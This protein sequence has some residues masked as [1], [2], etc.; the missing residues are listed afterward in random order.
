MLDGESQLS[1]SYTLS[2]LQSSVVNFLCCYY[3]VMVIGSKLLCLLKCMKKYV[4][5]KCCSPAPEWF[6]PKEDDL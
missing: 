4:S 5:G 3:D 1:C 2:S 6:G